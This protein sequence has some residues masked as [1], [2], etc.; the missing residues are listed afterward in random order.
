MEKEDFKIKRGYC[1]FQI[2]QKLFTLLGIRYIYKLDDEDFAKINYEGKIKEFEEI[3]NL[4]RARKISIYG[5]I[6]IIKYYNAKT[7][8]PFFITAQPFRTDL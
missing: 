2:L 4:W 3:P 8:P 7:N 5:K 1:M 6:S